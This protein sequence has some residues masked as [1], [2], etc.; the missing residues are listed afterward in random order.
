MEFFGILDITFIF[1]REGK[2][3]DSAIV[4]SF[5]EEAVTAM[6]SSYYS[7]FTKKRNDLRIHYR[8]R[9]RDFGATFGV[10]TGQFS[11]RSAAS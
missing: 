3:L 4:K 8:G 9:E 2:V 1:L 6:K 11:W 10:K 7:R 5:F